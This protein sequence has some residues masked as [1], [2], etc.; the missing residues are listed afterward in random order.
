MT[1]SVLPAAAAL[2]IALAAGGARAQEAV[3]DTAQAAQ[4]ATAVLGTGTA[5]RLVVTTPAFAPMF[6]IRCSVRSR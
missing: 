4:L 5:A 2:L 6:C 1:R 3:T